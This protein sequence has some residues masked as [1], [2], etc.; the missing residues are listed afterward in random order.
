[1]R[2]TFSLVDDGYAAD[3]P[4]PKVDV[5]QVQRWYGV[6]RAFPDTEL[7]PHI[8]R[9]GAPVAVAGQGGLRAAVQHGNHSSAS[10]YSTEISTRIVE[11]VL[12]G[13]ALY[14]RDAWR[15]NIRGLEC[16]P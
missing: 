9:D 15:Q 3:V 12:A 5:E 6:V 16:R 2:I 1:M 4:I 7:L 10:Q 11:D 14:S 13:R 8:V